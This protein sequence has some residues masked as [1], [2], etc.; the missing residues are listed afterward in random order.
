MGV[1]CPFMQI[2][3][4]NS[5]KI[6][7]SSRSNI[8]LPRIGGYHPVPSLSILSTERLGTAMSQ[9]RINRVTGNSN[10]LEAIGPGVAVLI[11][12]Y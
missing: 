4:K 8:L 2:K 5:V 7:L 11:G 10:V 12:E 6:G 9:H 1:P 3:W